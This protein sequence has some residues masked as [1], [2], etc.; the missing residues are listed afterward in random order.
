MPRIRTVYGNDPNQVP[1]D[2]YEVLAAIA[3]R[4]FFVSAPVR[5]DNFENTVCSEGG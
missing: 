1:F 5:D 4:N 3:P 2:F